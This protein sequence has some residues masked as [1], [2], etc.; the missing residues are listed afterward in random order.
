MFF[1]FLHRT[2]LHVC[3]K[4]LQTRQEIKSKGGAGRAKPCTCE[5][6]YILAE[7]SSDCTGSSALLPV[8]AQ[9]VFA[10]ESCKSP[11]SLLFWLLKHRGRGK[12]GRSRSRPAT[13]CSVA[14]LIS[15]TCQTGVCRCRS[16][17]DL[18]RP[19]QGDGGQVWTARMEKPEGLLSCCVCSCVLPLCSEPPGHHHHH[20]RL[21]L[22]DLSVS[23]GK[24]GTPTAQQSHST[25]GNRRRSYSS[26]LVPEH[27]SRLQMLDKSGVIV[28]KRELL[29]RAF[30]FHSAPAQGR[31]C[32]ISVSPWPCFMGSSQIAATTRHV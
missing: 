29:Q 28:G 32:S 19:E 13:T 25:A 1:L 15:H 14:H 18:W 4:T 2:A 30:H 9:S 31:H 17:D 7:A 6:Q 21:G 16:V 8:P 24:N 12:P 26:D 5:Q 20:R 23:W 3:H 11:C 10:A 27:Y 22:A